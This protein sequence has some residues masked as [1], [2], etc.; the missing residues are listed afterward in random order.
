MKSLNNNTQVLN[1]HYHQELT[2]DI[3]N[4]IFYSLFTAGVIDGTFSFS[5][6]TTSVTISSVSFL[7][8]PQNQPD[9]LVRIDT[10]EPI[11]LTNTS[12]SNIYL[13]ARYRWEN[14]NTG[15]E[16]L[17]IDDANIVE[18]DVILIGLVIDE[19]NKIINLDYDMQE[20]A[21]LK[22]IQKNILYPLISQLD[23]YRVGHDNDKIPISDGILN[24]SLN[25]QYFNGK[26]VTE[27]AVSKEKELPFNNGEVLE[28]DT[29][30]IVYPS[31]MDVDAVNK[32]DGITAEFL[33]DY[34]IQPQDGNTL[35]GLYDKIP[36]SNTTLQ[37][38]LNVGLL[39]GYGSDYFAKEGHTHTLD[40][41]IEGSGY[42]SVGGMSGINQA[43]PNSI[44]EDGITYRE[45][46]PLAYDKSVEQKYS[47]I[48]ETGYLLLE[49]SVSTAVTFANAQNGG[50]GIN[51]ARVFLQRIPALGEIAETTPGMEKR[52][53]RIMSITTQ[54][55]TAQQMGSIRP[56]GND[57][58][59]DD[60]GDIGIN[61]YYY[62]VIGKKIEVV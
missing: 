61:Q 6:G 57:Y 52:T 37:K 29:E 28:E 58:I 44:E 31:W 25:A 55:F 19:N 41:L 13:I 53:A 62:F 51:D 35:P 12:L 59:I 8:H 5:S 48:Y 46:T 33:N 24:T 38:E 32:G 26:E 43:G 60:E 22:A 30:P 17:F 20:R 56:E 39:N 34:A 14:E 45:V 9:L 18:T 27:Y 7:I 54:G 50:L 21:R 49:G 15:A 4:K 16:F 40:E 47:P 11:T 1:I 42:Y 23:G 36:I 10:T 3:L 2:S